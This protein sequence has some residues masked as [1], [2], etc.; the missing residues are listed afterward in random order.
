M[1]KLKILFILFL[2]LSL[3]AQWN[4]VGLIGDRCSPHLNVKYTF[5]NYDIGS[6]GKRY[7]IYKDG[8]LI[9][10]GSGDFGCCSLVDLQPISD[11][12]VFKLVN[13]AGI[14]QFFKSINSGKS[15]TTFGKVV[16]LYAQKTIFLNQHIG[17]VLVKNYLDNTLEIS[18]VS[19][20]NGQVLINKDTIDT[21]KTLNILTD[22]ILGEPFCSN[23]TST[24]FS[25]QRNGVNIDYKINIFSQPL[26]IKNNFLLNTVKIYPTTVK[27]I[28]FIEL[29][30]ESTINFTDEVGR[31]FYQQKLK[32]GTNHVNMSNFRTG[33][34]FIVLQNKTGN[35]FMNT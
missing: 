1:M 11:T 3:N 8:F 28:L 22:T 2:P 35:K 27:D 25:I 4:Y 18:R 29:E 7:N 23:L 12:V 30:Q 24:G 26:E 14:T 32:I 10:N 19:D 6:H 33:L 5:N 20:I 34:Y 13:D 21:S 15:W 31:N 17:Y 16:E 9:N